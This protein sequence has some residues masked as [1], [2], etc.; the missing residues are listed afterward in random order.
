MEHGNTKHFDRKKFL[1]KLSHKTLEFIFNL[2]KELPKVTSSRILRWVIKIMTFNLDIVYVKGNTIPQVDA[3]SRLQFKNET[4][5]KQE[6]AEDKIIHWVEMD[7]LP[8]KK[9]KIETKQD[10]ILSRIVERIRNN[11]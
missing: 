6:I 4:E 10:P 11:V 2:R 1:L 3:L 9:F 5:E 7:V 8:L